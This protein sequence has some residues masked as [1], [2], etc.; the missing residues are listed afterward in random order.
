[1]AR[2]PTFQLSGGYALRGIAAT[3][4]L[5]VGGGIVLAILL[6]FFPFFGFFG[7]FLMYGL[8]Y[9]I[10]EGLSAAVNRRR[11]R[12]YQYMAGAATLIAT[13]PILVG[14]LAFGSL[15]LSSLFTLVGIVIAVA[16]AA[17]RLRP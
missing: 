4:A 12:P 5:G 13:S 14:T 9:L 8:G 6:S 3:V 2:L 1:M 16:V 17:G 10:G 11:G 15:S 7:F